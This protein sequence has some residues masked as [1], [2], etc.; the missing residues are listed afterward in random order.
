ME[1]QLAKS[2]WLTRLTEYLRSPRT[3]LWHGAILCDPSGMTRTITYE[4]DGSVVKDAFTWSDVVRVSAFKRDVFSYDLICFEFETVGG[5]VEVGED[6]EGW[7][8]LIDTLPVNLPGILAEDDWFAKVALP[9]F[10][11]NWTTLFTRR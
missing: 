7:R 9:P 3:R 11:T 4:D 6:M 10:A 2:N 5:F 1:T 8:I